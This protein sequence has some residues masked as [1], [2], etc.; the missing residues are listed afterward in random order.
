[1]EYI[2]KFIFNGDTGKAN[3]FF[4]KNRKA[5]TS[6]LNKKYEKTFEEDSLPELFNSELK[7]I[8]DSEKKS[9]KSKKS[10]LNDEQKQA[11]LALQSLGYSKTASTSMVKGREGDSS[12]IVYEALKAAGSKGGK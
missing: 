2:S 11:A 1:M 5:V 3:K 7:N 6:A 8:V 9:V 4:E 10:P 12:Q